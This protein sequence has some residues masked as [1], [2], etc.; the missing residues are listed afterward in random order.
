MKRKF[1]RNNNSDDDIDGSKEE[2]EEEKVLEMGEERNG[3][4]GGSDGYD[5]D[6]D[7]DDIDQGIDVINNDIIETT[8]ATMSKMSIAALG[9]QKDIM[10]KQE[11]LN[12]ISTNNDRKTSFLFLTLFS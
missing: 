8:Q 12:D 10:A 4:E 1:K 9:M 3:N 6:D 2:E 7:D 5:D 11:H